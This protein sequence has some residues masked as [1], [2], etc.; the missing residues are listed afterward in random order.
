MGGRT[1]LKTKNKKMPFGGHVVNTQFIATV[2]TNYFQ[3]LLNSLY[4]K[5]LQ[6]LEAFRNLCSSPYK[7]ALKGFI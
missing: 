7:R 4:R 5:D 6:Q 1:W 3:P 2:R